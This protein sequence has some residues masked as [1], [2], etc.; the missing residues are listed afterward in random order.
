MVPKKGS[1]IQKNATVTAASISRSVS[2]AETAGVASGESACGSL[3]VDSTGAADAGGE[4]GVAG[5]V[6]VTAGSLGA[7]RVWRCSPAHPRVVR[8]ERP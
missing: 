7:R 1:R 5:V 3:E 8:R 6:M 2:G 4:A